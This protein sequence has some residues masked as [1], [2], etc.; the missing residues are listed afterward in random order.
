MSTDFEGKVA[1]ITGAAR[2]QG[3]S[4]AV[5]FAE[6]GADIFAVDI[7]R[8][9]DS[10]G[11]PMAG[12]EDLDETVNLVEKTGRR[13]VA[14]QVD[15]R[16]FDKLKAV[17]AEGVSELGRIDFV[18]AN[19]GILPMVGAQAQEIS[20]FND[21]VDVMLKGVH[22]TI[23]AALPALLQHGDGGAIVITSSSA[24]LSGMHTRFGMKTQGA[25]GYVAAKEGVVGLMRYYANAL[26]EKNIRVNTVHPTGVA[27]PMIINEAVNQLMAGQ[28]GY[29]EA[30]ANLMPVTLIEVSDISDAMVYL[31]GRSGRYITGITLPVDAGNAVR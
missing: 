20:A 9:I 8:Q 6:E 30:L 7:C 13:I 17:V 21:A 18:L 25:L 22:Y 3:R 28:P 23:D 16:D 2:G 1:F 10:V 29:E 11:Y 27:T 24:S 5:R 31:C 15:V 26:G 19:A 14:E 12:P 4:H